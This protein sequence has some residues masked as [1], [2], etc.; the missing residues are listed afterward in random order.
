MEEELSETEFF[1]TSLQN[2]QNLKDKIQDKEIKDSFNSTFQIFHFDLIKNG[3]NLQKIIKK[4]EKKIQYFIKELFED[5]WMIFYEQ[6][7][8]DY[9]PNSE[10]IENWKKFYYLLYE[11]IKKREILDLFLEKIPY[12]LSF[13]QFQLFLTLRTYETI[14]YYQF[15][16]I[17]QITERFFFL[18]N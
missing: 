14:E 3:K 1:I 7:P 5:I 9:P 15:P 10:I 6:L 11:N 16:H 8:S 13:C 2:S 17:N 4:Y 12:F 18:F